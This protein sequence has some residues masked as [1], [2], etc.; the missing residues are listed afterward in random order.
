M[1]LLCLLTLFTRLPFRS[2][3]LFDQDSVQFA[4]GM[5]TYDVY[6]HQP[7]PP[8]Y[9]LYI[10]TA[11]LINGFVHDPNASLVWISV[12]ASVLAVLTTYH[13]A[14]AIFERQ[15][16]K[17]A[18]L[19]MVTSPAIWFHGEVALTYILAAMF[20]NIIG[21]ISWKLLKG[22][23]RWLYIS[24][25]VLGIAAGFRQDLILFLGP[26]WFFAAT[27]FG[28]R[29]T[30]KV[31]ILLA[32]T[33]SLWLFPMLAATGG[34]ERYFNA[35][36]ELWQFNNDGQLL[37][38]STTA[39]RADTFWTLAG[40]LSYGVE[41][42][43]VF[44]IFACYLLF[45]TGK[46]RNLQKD[47]WLFFVLWLAPALLF[48]TFIF[49]PP[50]KYAYGLVIT[51]AFILLI[52]QAVRLVVSE[53]RKCF[54]ARNQTFWLSPRWILPALVAI[55]AAVFC[56]STSGF[57]VASLRNHEHVLT[58]IFA[59]IEQNFPSKSTLIL[60]RQ[61]STFSGFRHIQLYLPEYPVY[62]ADQQTNQ[63]SEKWHAFGAR[64]GETVLADG[65]HIPPGVRYVVFVADPYFPETSRDLATPGIHRLPL[66][67]QYAL[68]FEDL[69]ASTAKAR[70]IA[71]H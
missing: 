14:S 11:K 63:H 51:P 23:R 3:Y 69:S 7:H 20:A 53:L 28:W 60:G 48:F 9:F 19:L 12:I 61:S 45:R 44:L 35:L 13:L 71:S 49:I 65:I 34:L 2:R 56:L 66:N 64:H 39:S 10:E 46:W 68:Y 27:R 25:V 1:L 55:N 67:G 8:G 5:K 50:Y 32:A 6:L 33:V 42:G 62:L 57:S 30:V 15:D 22:D 41:V 24:P 40:F 36:V 29:N 47:V 31:L 70:K 18:A 59:G 43:A 54:Q 26:L 52:P 17:W 4:L 37:W 58:M 16:G 21:L 38:Q